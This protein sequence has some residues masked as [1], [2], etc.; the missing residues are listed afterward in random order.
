MKLEYYITVLAYCLLTNSIAQNSGFEL[1]R[2]AYIENGINYLNSNSII[3]QA[4]K[5][6]P[7]DAT[8]L[9]TILNNIST[10]T[11]ADFDIVKLIRILFLSNG[12]YDNTILPI[13]EPI[14]FWLTKNED[15]RAYWSENHMIMWM[16]SDWL[17]HEKYGKTVDA[18]LN[19]RLKHLLK[20]KVDYGFYEFFS[21]VYLP[22]SLSG[23]LNLADFS[24]D[25][26]IKNLATQAAQRLLKDILMLTNNQGVFFPVAGRNYFNKYTSAYDQNHNSL[27]YLLTGFGE[28]PTSTS[29]SGSFLATSTID[30]SS[31]ISSWTSTLNTSFTKGHSLKD[32]INNINQSLPLL[33]KVIFQW[34]SGAYFHPDVALNTATILK[35]YN[36]WNHEQFK[37]FKDFKGL[38]MPIA[39]TLAE[40]ASSISKSSG[41]Y[42][43]TISIF[44]NNSVTLSSVQDFW[45]GKNGYQEFPLVANTGTSAVF[46]ISGKV[47]DN[48]EDRPDTH[49]NTHLPYIKQT[50][51][52]ALV[53]Y[54]PEKGLSLFGYSDDKLDVALHWNPDIFDEIREDGNW[55]LGREKDGYIAV[56]RHCTD[57][58]KNT[59]ACKNKDGQTWVFMVGN[60]I[61]YGN[62]DNFE[63]IIKA[64]VFESKWYFDLPTLQW[65]YQSKITIDNKVLEY[66]WYADI[67]S[68]PTEKDIPTSITNKKSIREIA[69][70][71]N[72]ANSFINIDIPAQNIQ[73]LQLKIYNSVGAEIY[74]EQKKNSTKTKLQINTSNFENGIYYIMLETN[75]NIYTGK[76]SVQK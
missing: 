47:N 14:P 54:R 48:L 6:I 5:N 31:V 30:V 35:E 45:K 73:N 57:I 61:M 39:P 50:D 10:N 36:L 20:L 21:S 7:V 22:Y 17:L 42:N 34:S 59:M 13:L 16:S 55:I 66:T 49:A 28:T 46:T 19:S 51:N 32:G 33:D 18:D 23:L 60:D 24:E 53:M 52:I 63:A 62:F 37:D 76:V 4:Y 65:A 44:K 67:F 15:T 11:T 8:T 72:P 68:G 58:I 27:I 71:P 75:D 12:E 64:S 69:V 56:R 43:P 25:T 38:P 74:Q 40:I 41:I 2:N 3:F 26:E 70:Y 29:H 9:N 1:R